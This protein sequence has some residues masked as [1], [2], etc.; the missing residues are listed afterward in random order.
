QAAAAQAELGRRLKE[1]NAVAIPEAQ[2]L[3]WY[4]Q[5]PTALREQTEARWGPPP[6]RLMV[7]VDEAGARSI[8]IPLLR[9][10]KVALAPHPVWGYLQDA[11]ALSSTGALPPHHQYIAFY[12]WMARGWHADAYVPFFTQLSLMPGKQQGPARDD[13][14]GTLIGGLPHVQPTPLQANGGIGNKRRAHAVTLGFMPPL[15]QG[16]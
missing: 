8:V 5:L 4:A 12:L 3:E 1:G 11:D 15:M 13:W 2:Y 14:I 10:G 16:G 6:G 7:R 9:F